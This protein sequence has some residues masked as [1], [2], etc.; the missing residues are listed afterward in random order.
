VTEGPGPRNSEVVR[1]SLEAI[2]AGDLQ[3]FRRLA[4]DHAH[5]DVEWT[6]LIGA[7]VEGS[8]RGHGQIEAFFSD[9][10]GSFEVRYLDPDLK[11]LGDDVVVLLGGMRLTGRHSG[12]VVERELAAVFEFEDGSLRRGTAFATRDE[13][14]AAAHKLVVEGA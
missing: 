11:A 3:G 5:P 10:L 6:P 8:Y 4:D 9:Y 1:R 13:A 2:E 7:G 14:L 12:A